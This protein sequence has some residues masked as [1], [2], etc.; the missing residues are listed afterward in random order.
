MICPEC[1]G[2]EITFLDKIMIRDKGNVTWHVCRICGK[3][4]ITKEY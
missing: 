2:N 4:I 1:K 3:I